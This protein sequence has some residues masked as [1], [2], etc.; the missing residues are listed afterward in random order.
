[1]RDDVVFEDDALLDVLE[2]PID[3]RYDTL[4]ASLVARSVA[5][6]D[7]TFPSER[8]LYNADGLGYK[9][10]F[11]GACRLIRSIYGDEQLCWANLSK[12]V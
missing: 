5:T 6:M 11:S 2:E 4:A 12:N 1:M 8:R 3:C 7:I 9:C 10:C